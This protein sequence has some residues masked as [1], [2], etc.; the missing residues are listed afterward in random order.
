MSSPSLFNQDTNTPDLIIY[1]DGGA[2]GNPGPA[3]TGYVIQDAKGNQLYSGGSYIGD[4]TN[5][6]AEYQAVYEALKQVT[7]RSDH[8]PQPLH[9]IHVYVDSKLIANQLNGNF[10][11]KQPHLKQLVTKINAL[12]S[13]H[14]LNV[15]YHQV[16]REDNQAA[17]EQVNKIL[18]QEVGPRY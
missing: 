10:K 15:S 2:R 18:D 12:I 8:Y 9:S 6:T 11:I 3:A 17:D 1:S 16:P 4:A 14:Q 5:N 7:N 13:D